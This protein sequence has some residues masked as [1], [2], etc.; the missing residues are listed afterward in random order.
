MPD[1]FS[2]V[3]AQRMAADYGQRNADLRKALR[4]AEAQLEQERTLSRRAT[5]ILRLIGDLGP[6]ARALVAEIEAER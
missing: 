4:I 6:E 1:A 2:H 3:Y 5:R